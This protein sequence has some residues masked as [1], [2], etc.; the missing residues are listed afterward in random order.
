MEIQSRIPQIL[1]KINGSAIPPEAAT[2]VLE[3]VIESSLHLPDA[4][5]IRIHD[6]DFKWLDHSLF[7]EG[8]QVEVLV[9]EEQKPVQTIFQGEISTLELDLAGMG[10]PMLTVRCMDKAH[11]L[12]RGRERRTFLNVKDSDIVQKVGSEGGFQ[13]K[14]DTTSHIHPW[15]LQNNQTNWEF[16]TMLAQRNGYRL[17]LEGKE[18]LCF[19]KVSNSTPSTIRLEW[20]KELRSF[21]IRTSSSRQVDEVT[22]RGWDPAKKQVIIGSA[23]RAEGAAQIGQRGDG[24][25]VAKQ[26]FGAA[27]MVVVDRPISSQ[28]EATTMAQSIIDDIGTSFIEA[29]GLCYQQPTLKPGMTVQLANIGQRF[30]GKYIVTATTHTLSAAEG[31]S[32][33][34]VISGKNPA[35][36]LSLLGGV[37][38]G[39]SGTQASSPSKGSPNAGNIVVGLVT[40]NNDPLNQGRVK[41]KYPWLSDQDQSDWARVAAPMAGPDRGFLFTPEVNDEVLVAFEHGDVNRP[42]VIGSLWNG[43]DSPPISTGDTVAS[44]KVR[45]RRITTRYGH[46]LEFDDDGDIVLMTAQGEEVLLEDGKGLRL[47]SK[48]G[49]E[50]FVTDDGRVVAVTQMGKFLAA[51]DKDMSIAMGDEMGNIISID[52][53]SQTITLKSNMALNITSSGVMNITGTM[54]NINSGGGGGAS[55]PNTKS[56]M[57][58]K[59]PKK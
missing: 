24:G 14:A 37:G 26:A 51:S 31:L 22:V 19:K 21:R 39:G 43:K 36:L 40:D 49:Q 6:S 15:V 44:A 57:K 20:G 27:K 50:I 46:T 54:V 58:N 12:H 38:G 13:I 41:V 47:K 1:I 5:A 9:S 34:F 18:T 7:Q 10:V 33:Q 55:K 16:L 30:N 52:S 8:K 28:S 53:K 59:A 11:R 56:D 29:D 48:T 17:Y 42:Y 2:A 4:C 32:T 3:T 45:R 35:T 25:S 23:K